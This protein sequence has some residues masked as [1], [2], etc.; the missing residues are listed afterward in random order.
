MAAR[1]DQMI[2]ERPPWAT[3][4]TKA[5][6][7]DILQHPSVSKPWGIYVEDIGNTKCF[8]L[9]RDKILLQLIQKGGA[10]EVHICC[11]LRDRAGMF[12]TLVGVLK[13][14][15][16]YGWKQIYTTAPQGRT[17]LHRMLKN[18]DFIEHNQR[19]TYHGHGPGNDG[20]SISRG[21][22]AQQ[23]TERKVCPQ[24]H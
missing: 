15:A 12:D 22:P 24:G 17:A 13:W 16:Q 10:L 7:L 2:R 3:L 18:L 8:L 9:L 11:K 20:G 19:W 21:K 23:W 6:A 1:L 4:P 5:Q 14:M